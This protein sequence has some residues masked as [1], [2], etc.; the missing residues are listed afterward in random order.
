MVNL[1]ITLTHGRKAKLRTATMAEAEAL[2]GLLELNPS[3]KSVEVK[4]C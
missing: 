1:M 3:I 2:K 4:P